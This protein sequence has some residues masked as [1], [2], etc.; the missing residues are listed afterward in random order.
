MQVKPTT[1]VTTHHVE[2]DDDELAFLCTVLGY[3]VEKDVTSNS[4]KLERGRVIRDRLRTGLDS[5]RKAINDIRTAMHLP[6]VVY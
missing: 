2:L 3:A 1:M 5:Q 6:V 4:D